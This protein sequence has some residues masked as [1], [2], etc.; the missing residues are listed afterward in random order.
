MSTSNLD[1]LIPPEMAKKAEAVGE[2]KAKMPVRQM[3]VLSVLAGAFIALGAMFSTTATTGLSSILPYGLTRVVAGLTFSLGLVLV[4]VAGAEL[5][6][7]N[8]LVVMA[9]ASGR[10]KTYELLGGW[11]L[12]YIGNFLGAVATAWLVFQSRLH[13]SAGGDVGDL[14]VAIAAQKCEL[15][16]W[17][18][19]VRGVLCNGL[20]CLAVWLSFSARTT[21][22]RILA[23]VGP[24]T[25]FVA[26]GFEHSVA[27]MYF[28]PHGIWVDQV[29]EASSA[30]AFFTR[31]ERVSGPS[32]SG[33]LDNLFPVTLGNMVGGG[34][35]VGMIYWWVYRVGAKP[36]QP[37]E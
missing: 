22:D 23:I 29:P 34:G 11:A 4:V 28:I 31:P 21:T 19:F 17:T 30:T 37:A 1:A 36:D 20:V 3:F 25:A 13:E 5:F 33:F 35:L 16:F 10:V 12:V 15:G 6:T 27:N 32:W 2:A 9:W 14:A 7:G 8:N 18:A 26:C 24:V